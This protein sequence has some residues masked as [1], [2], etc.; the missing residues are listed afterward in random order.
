MT[1]G[2]YSETLFIIIKEFC[3][4]HFKRFGELTI[5]E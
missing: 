5:P 3:G 1:A 2:L 4:A